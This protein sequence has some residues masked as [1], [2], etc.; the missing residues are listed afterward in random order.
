MSCLEFFIK[1]LNEKEIIEMN[2]IFNLLS[3]NGDIINYKKIGLKQK[4]YI[5][6]H[7]VNLSLNVRDLH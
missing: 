5:L 1:G 4:I 6:K 3:K 2:E 7:L